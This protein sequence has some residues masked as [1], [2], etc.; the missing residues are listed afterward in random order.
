MGAKVTYVLAATTFGVVAAF[1]VFAAIVWLGVMDWDRFRPVWVGSMVPAVVLA[2]WIVRPILIRS[3]V[4]ILV[5]G[6]L[7]AV[8]SAALFGFCV[9]FSGGIGAD[10]GIG[11]VLV[12]AA[13]G[14]L[15]GIVA[16]LLLGLVTFPLGFAGAWLL[17]AVNRGAAS[18]PPRGASSD[19]AHH[20]R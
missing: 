14:G 2:A 3:S 19:A 16:S 13:Y 8:V 10:L 4:P 17:H 9:V 15:M 20:D 5:V 6:A 7:F 18:P 11:E 12:L 1:V